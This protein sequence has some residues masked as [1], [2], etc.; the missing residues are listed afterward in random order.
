M[1]IAA[2]ITLVLVVVGIIFVFSGRQAVGVVSGAL[3]LLP[4]TG[5]VIFNRMATDLDARSE[6]TRSGRKRTERCC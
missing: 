4:G 6:R 2:I 5:T 1:M 3:A